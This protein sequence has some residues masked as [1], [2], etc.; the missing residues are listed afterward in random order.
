MLSSICT[1]L[2]AATGGRCPGALTPVKG[3]LSPFQG[4][5]VVGAS[6]SQGSAPSPIICRPFG[7]L[8]SFALH[9]RLRRTASQPLCSI[10]PHVRMLPIRI[11]SVGD[12]LQPSG[13][14]HSTALR[15]G[16]SL[17]KGPRTLT[18]SSAS[19]PDVLLKGYSAKWRCQRLATARQAVLHSMLDVTR[20]RNGH[21]SRRDRHKTNPVS[22]RVDPLTRA[23]FEEVCSKSTRPMSETVSRLLRLVILGHFNPYRGKKRRTQ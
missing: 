5:T 10:I 3:L 9:K 1:E 4:S 15:P 11:V 13:G 22:V 14:R 21:A 12:C 7:A 6:P 20:A 8:S 16:G 18:I 17:P 19:H 2:P 23:T